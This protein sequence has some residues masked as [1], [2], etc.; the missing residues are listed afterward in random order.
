MRNWRAANA[1]DR[2]AVPI[3]LAQQR[4][5]RR[6]LTVTFPPVT[7]PPSGEAHQDLVN[8]SVRTTGIRRCRCSRYPG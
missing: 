4:L 3:Y 1:N 2:P 8:H 7:F 5:R 6:C